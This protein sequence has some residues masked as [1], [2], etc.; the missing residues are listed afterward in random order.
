MLKYDRVSMGMLLKEGR[1]AAKLTQHEAAKRVG[2]TS[3]QFISN[4][5]RG[6]CVTPLPLLKKFLGLYKMSP[7]AVIDVLINGEKEY[8]L[9]AFG[10]KAL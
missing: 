3:P 1:N 7:N 5:E 6:V 9:K 10:R 4:I 2:H 8:L